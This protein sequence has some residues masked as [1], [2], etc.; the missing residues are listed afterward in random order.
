[1][2]DVGNV[3]AADGWTE[4]ELRFF[5]LMKRVLSFAELWVDFCVCVAML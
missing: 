2:A 3:E 1:M 4:A 5:W